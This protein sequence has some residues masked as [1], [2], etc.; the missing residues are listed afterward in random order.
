M[1]LNNLIV[2]VKYSLKKVL[3]YSCLNTFEKRIQLFANERVVSADL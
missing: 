3:R 2:K 1:G